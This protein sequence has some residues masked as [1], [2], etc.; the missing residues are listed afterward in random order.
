MMALAKMGHTVLFLSTRIP[1][2]A[3]NS[4]LETT[5]ARAILAHPRFIGLACEF[6]K[7][8][9]GLDV[10]EIVRAQVFDFSIDAHVD[11]RVGSSLDPETETGNFAFIIHSSGKSLVV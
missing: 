8:I 1:Q 4:L 7:S 5:S 6:R 9:P 10:G 2:E 11:T 3:V